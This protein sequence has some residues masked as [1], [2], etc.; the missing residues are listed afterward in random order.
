VA[1]RVWGVAGDRLV[2]VLVEPGSEGIRVVGLPLDRGRTTA[3][4]VRAALVNSGL[5][6]C[7]LSAAVRL[8]PALP[9]GGATSD[10][11]LPIA[12]GVLAHLGAL[13]TKVRWLMATGRL[14]LDGIVH[15]EKLGER[16]SLADVLAFACHTP[17]VGFEHVFET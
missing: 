16:I 9:G 15:A 7:S 17:A 11:D 10:L 12:L 4:R 13:D 1:V 6:R 2:E 5:V 3:D 8:D 14:G